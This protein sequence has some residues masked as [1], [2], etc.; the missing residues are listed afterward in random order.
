MS[1]FVPNAQRYQEASEPHKSKEAADEAIKAF[2]KEL[3]ELRL[4]YHIKDLLTI[5]GVSILDTDCS[6][7][8]AMGCNGFGN[9]TL[10]LA[11]AAF[12]YGQEKAAHQQLIA[13]L[14]AGN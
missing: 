11:M 2:F 3:G 6:E 12:G 1:E 13:K 8:V 4:K 9:Q 14:L 10:W 5:Y 7:S